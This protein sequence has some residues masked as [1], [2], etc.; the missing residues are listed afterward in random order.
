LQSVMNNDKM[1]SLE[2][3]RESTSM[4]FIKELMVDYMKEL[5]THNK[6]PLKLAVALSDSKI[7][8]WAEVDDNDEETE[9]ALLLT[10]A[11]INSKYF[12]YGFYINS[13]ILEKSDNL[14]IP[15]HFQTIIG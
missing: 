9:D 4:N 2:L 1:K 12:Q 14:S 10:E 11:K 7:I 15:P 5:Q 3:V 6:L 8:V 13:T